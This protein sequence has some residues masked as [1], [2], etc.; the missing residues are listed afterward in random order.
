M[1]KFNIDVLID[2]SGAVKGAARVNR[3][4]ANTGSQVDRLRNQVNQLGGAW[5]TMLGQLAATVGIA[6]GIQ[7]VIT[8]LADFDRGMAQVAAIT[9]AAGDELKDLRDAAKE[10]GATTEFNARQG[11]EALLALGQAG[12]SAA[13][14]IT[15]LPSTVDLATAAQVDLA[16][17]AT[18][19]TESLSIFGLAAGQAGRVAD[20]FA[21]ASA[22]S[23]ASATGLG[24]AMK[25][26]GPIAAALGMSLEE[27]AAAISILNNAGIKGSSA[28]TGL[29][30]VLASLSAPSGVAREAIEG[31]GLSLEQ[32]NPATNDLIDIVRTLGAAGLDAGE[33]FKIFGQEGT[34]AILSFIASAESLDTMT[35]G[36]NDVA[37]EARK[38]ADVFRD[39]LGG[40]LDDVS[41][42]VEGLI[43]ALGD[44]GLIALL[45]LLA[46]IVVTVI[47]ALTEFV[48][49]VGWLLNDVLGLSTALN[50]LSGIMAAAGPIVNALITAI[51][52]LLGAMLI[53]HV[54]SFVAALLAM[55]LAMAG[56]N[57][58]VL[59]LSTALRGLSA[60]FTLVT[61]G[62]RIMTV[63]IMAN[64]IGFL[65]G[66]VAI[67]VSLLYQ[68][69]D[70]ISIG[71]GRLASLGDLAQA[72]W[73]KISSGLSVLVGF[74]SEVASSIGEMF[75]G[76]FQWIADLA[77]EVFGDVEF[78]ISGL[79][80]VVAQVIDFVIGAFTGAFRAIVGAWELIPAALKDI[81]IRAMN[82]VVS[83]VEAG[84]NKAI[85]ALNSIPGV[86]IGQAALGRIEND[87]AGAAGRVGAV[88]AEAFQSGFESSPALDAANGLLD[89]ADEIA[90]ERIGGT[91][92]EGG[93]VPGAPVIP[94]GTTLGMDTGGAAGAAG[95][96]GGA[97]SATFD[98][99]LG[100]LQQENELLQL[101]N[102][103]RLVRQQILSME[104]QLKRQ[105]TSTETEA[106]RQA[107]LMNE[108]LKV[109]DSIL[110][111]LRGPAE[112][113]RMTQE[114]LNTLYADGR[115]T[116]QEYTAAMRDL[117]VASTE[118]ANTM[119]GGLANGLARVAQEANNLG[120]GVS[121]WV[122]GAFSSATDAIVEFAKTGEFNVRQ[123]FQDL[124][125]QLLKL[126]TNQLF[127][128]IL[129]QFGGGSA[130]GGGGGLFAGLGSLLGFATGGD[131]VVGG[132]GGTD[133]QIV[134]FKATPNERISVRTPGQSGPGDGSSAPAAPPVVNVKNVNVT[135]P[136]EALNAL[137][138]AEG[139]R[140]ILNTI[141]R[142]PGA[143]KRILGAN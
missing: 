9:G 18:L 130:L 28:G 131:M 126:A 34:P 26:V 7:Q 107:V 42:G 139:E 136:R 110:Q 119:Q 104:D 15:A 17:A 91:A 101:N 84:V 93:V 114:A 61:T 116:L 43:I 124:F 31:L 2:P 103:E 81:M 44:A 29:R 5:G 14:S 83:I 141:K 49:L 88:V 62:I 134:A 22:R 35:T 56:G 143:F 105:L 73:E 94:P 45:R 48:D 102:Q 3:E 77:R 40:A 111:E 133:S 113:N 122:V 53:A 8:L 90:R 69:A 39:S 20:V 82:G 115:I 109:Q 54:Y 33:A 100:K 80:Q 70:V 106:V 96:G 10:V 142:N 58:I 57:P 37:G 12:L 87:A 74:M 36:L 125:A 55:N 63:A 86:D 11:A 75:T 108:Q 66:V 118:T 1:A 52:A 97:A 92:P 71:G 68:F 135:D 41:S 51:A 128:S 64:P 46:T 76:P 65:I 140:T 23:N 24:E 99:L 4:L 50:A 59:L 6:M 16:T 85:S 21:A 98:E 89:R 25:T 129:G 27:T 127:A 117:A 138:T 47:R 67:A 112:E 19:T 60:V 32:V 38:M 13:D 121:D 72:V 123:F 132:S 78:S 137:N 120:K 95:G 79:I 30:S